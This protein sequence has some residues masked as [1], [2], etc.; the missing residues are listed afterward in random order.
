[1]TDAF[2]EVGAAF[3]QQGA[4]E[5]IYNFASSGALA[6][7]LLAAPRADLFL[8]ANED[9]MDEVEAGGRLVDGSRR[10]LLSNRLVVIGNRSSHY[11]LASAAALCSPPFALLSLGDPASVPAGRYAREWLRSL[12]CPGGGSAWDRLEDRLAPAPDV[13]AALNQ[14][15]GSAAV[16][17][18]VYR[19][20]WIAR[21]AGVRLLL[22]VPADQ[23]PPISYQAAI[24]KTSKSPTLA[25][26]FLDFLS[27]PVARP[28][29]EK[30]GFLVTD[31]LTL[32][33]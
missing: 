30:H 11:E 20:D 8:S 21:R 4:A 29:F 31:G 28:L 17:G 32:G 14:V 1:L 15:I 27:G 10:T 7:Q 12:P 3:E 13:R 16:A 19:T 33:D 9:W 2:R 5:L 18:I 22:E 6:Q 24:L 26:E 25:H 23:G